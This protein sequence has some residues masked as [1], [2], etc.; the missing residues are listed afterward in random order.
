MARPNRRDPRKHPPALLGKRLKRLREAA[1]YPSQEAAARLLGWSRETLTKTENGERPPTD[2]VFDSY[3]EKFRATPE[4]AEYLTEDLE[5]ARHFVAQVPEF[6]EPWLSVE[7]Q[8]TQIEAWGLYAMPGQLQAYSYSLAMFLKGG[9]DEDRAAASAALRAR[10]AEILKGDKPTQLT[11]ILYEPVL[12][13]QVGSPETMVAEMEHLL[14]LS[15][16]PHVTILVVPECEY[17]PGREGQFQIA[18]GP[19]IPDTLNMIT[20]ADV[21]TNDPAVVARTIRLFGVIRG[22][23]LSVADSRARIQEARQRWKDRPRTPAGGSPATATAGRTP[24]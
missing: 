13:C 19:D 20:I 17:F 10:R 22:Y 18:S 21:T 14:K 6:A 16:L 8:A 23:A 3:L 12:Y 15:A 24:A 11:A 4:Q 7:P 5:L 1:G 9:M 2:L